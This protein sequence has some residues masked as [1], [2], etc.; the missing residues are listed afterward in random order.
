[1]VDKSDAPSMLM[2][3]TPQIYFDQLNN[4]H[5]YLQEIMDNKP[6]HEHDNTQSMSMEQVHYVHD[7]LN[8]VPPTTKRDLMEK[9]HKAAVNKM[10]WS[11]LVKA[12][13]WSEWEAVE[14]KQLNQYHEQKMFGEPCERQQG[15]GLFNLV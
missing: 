13:D 8:E 9:A 6:T 5:N 1:M 14:W 2:D 10:R 7:N 4:I 3:G 11:D 12:G 15:K